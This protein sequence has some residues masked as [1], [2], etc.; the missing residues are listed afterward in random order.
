MIEPFPIQPSLVLKALS[1]YFQH[2]GHRE[3]GALL[4][5]CTAKIVVDPHN[6]GYDDGVPYVLLIEVPPKLFG[7]HEAK[8]E[9]AE[10]FIEKGVSSIASGTPNQY[11]H[12]SR[13]VLQT[14]TPELEQPVR[15]EDEARFWKPGMF[16]L[17]LSHSARDRRAV[18]KLKDQLVQYGVDG[19]VAHKDIG[20]TRQWQTEIMF[21][22]RSMHGLVLLVTPQARSSEWVNQE[23][24]FALGRGVQVISVKLE[25]LHPIEDGPAIVDP[26]A[27]AGSEQAHE[28][29]FDDPEVL[30]REVVGVLLSTA[31]TAS[32]MRKALIH[33]LIHAR[34]FAESKACFKMVKGLP[35]ITA[36]EADRLK[37]AFA[38]TQVTN[39][40]VAGSLTDLIRQRDPDFGMPVSNEPPLPDDDEIPF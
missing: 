19:F 25:S 14:I 5:A 27:F 38:N 21:G 28:S 13:F 20:V 7:E 6:S 15:Q 4:N 30:A 40:W 23:I 36:A 10:K 24:G 2:A 9:E 39:T 22:L 33:S 3:I 37:A 16:R 17:F 32:T 26:P 35:N 29:S 31:K 34:N 12:R 18:T 1:E 11:L 8:L